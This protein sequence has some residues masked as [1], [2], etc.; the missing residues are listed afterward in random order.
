VKVVAKFAV[1][2]FVVSALCLGLFSYAFAKREATRIE[3]TL[4]RGLTSYGVALR[5]T[6]RTAWEEHGFT[7]AERIVQAFGPE[8]EVNAKLVL[9]DPSRRSLPAAEPRAEIVDDQGRRRIRVSLDVEGPPGAQATLVLDRSVVDGST[10]IRDELGDQLLATGILAIV[11][12]AL[13]AALGAILIGQPLGR[14]VAQARRIGEGDLTHRLRATRTDEIGVLKRELNSMCDRLEAAN[15]RV[16]EEATARIETLEKLRHLDRLRTVG[17][18]AS[19]IAHE[20][21]TPLNVLLLRGQSLAKGD[22]DPSDIPAAGAAVVNQVEKMSRIVRQLLGFVR[23]RG[24][25]ESK[26]ERVELA[27]VARHASSLLGSM[28]KKHGVA[29]SVESGEDV[30]VHGDFGQIEQALTNLIVNGIQAMPKGGRLDVRVSRKLGTNDV[31]I[32]VEDEGT[33]MPPEV[34]QRV[35]DPFYTTKPEG[36][37]TGLGLHVARGIV[38]DHGGSIRA[39]SEVGKGSTFELHL[40]GVS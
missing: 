40:P 14:I 21:G 37:G 32:E 39:R 31:V 16:E 7:A 1:A 27:G 20:L 24:A 13:A 34:A 3:R 30:A 8:G 38:E 36:E 28:A 25:L 19:G 17:T 29:L 33:G 15:A 12:A 35:F 11:M 5:P 2:F 18:L 22:V 10:I 23:T 9:A 4:T 6:L 26:R